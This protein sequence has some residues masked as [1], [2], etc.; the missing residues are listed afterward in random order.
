MACAECHGAELAGNDEPFR[1]DLIV[2]SAYSLDEFKTLMGRGIP[3]GGRRL[4]LMA[5]VAVSRFS[6]LNDE[7][8]E[9]L[10]R[11]LTARAAVQ[12]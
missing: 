4:D 2:A 10:Y 8:I 1:P 9:A 12:Q 3:T 7:E 11:Y 5:K 6:N